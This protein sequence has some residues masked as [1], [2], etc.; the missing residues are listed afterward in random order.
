MRRQR[1]ARELRVSLVDVSLSPIVRG[2]KYLFL[3]FQEIEERADADGLFAFQNPSNGAHVIAVGD[4]LLCHF[5]FG[6]QFK[7]F[8]TIL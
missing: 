2:A 5:Q 6:L 4:Y 8:E 3:T 7:A 1:I